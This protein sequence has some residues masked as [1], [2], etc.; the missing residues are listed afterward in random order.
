MGDLKTPPGPGSL[1][2][3]I[4]MQRLFTPAGP[5]PTPW[6]ER[7]LPHIVRICD[8]AAPRNLLTRFIPPARADDA[9]GMWRPYFAKWHAVTGQELAP[10]WLDIV[11]ELDRFCC[12]ETVFDRS[13]YSLFFDGRLHRRLRQARIDTLIVSGGETDVCV[14]SSVLAAVDHGYRVLLVED[15]LCSSSDASHD[16]MTGLFRRRYDVQVELVGVEELLSCW[17]PAR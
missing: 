5:W 7:V 13:V 2:V 6:L 9:G 3:C 11:P 1:H 10:E 14:L 8:H 15:A 4:D 17:N 12:P 16:A